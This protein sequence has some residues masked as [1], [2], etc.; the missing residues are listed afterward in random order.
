MLVK[1][2]RRPNKA[3]IGLSERWTAN[4]LPELLEIRAAIR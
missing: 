2:D 1:E 3:S 4:E